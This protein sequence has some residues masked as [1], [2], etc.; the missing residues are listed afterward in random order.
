PCWRTGLSN[1]QVSIYILFVIAAWI[2]NKWIWILVSFFSLSIS[3]VLFCRSDRINNVLFFI[4]DCC[5]R[6][7]EREQISEKLRVAGP[8]FTSSNCCINS[9]LFSRR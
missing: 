3:I 6:S 2:G 7:K 5:S 1:Q 9:S 8:I 4:S